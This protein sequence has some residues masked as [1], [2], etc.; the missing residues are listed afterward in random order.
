MLHQIA[1]ALDHQDYP[2]AARLL[3]QALQQSPHD[4]W[5][6]FYRARLYEVSGKVDPAEQIY[7]QLL[8]DV[9]NPK[10]ALQVRQGLQR[11]ETL[12]QAQ[13]QQAIA[14]A[15][16]QPGSQDPGFL[17]LEA[18]PSE[19]RSTVTQ[20]L[21]RV[22]QLDA[23]TAR[24]LVP[25]RGW[26]LYRTGAIGELG[27]HGR[28]LRQAGVPASWASQP[29]LEQI[30][31]FQVQ[32]FQA[33][34]PQVEVICKNAQDQLGQLNFDWTEVQQRVEG[35][36][37]I[38]EQVLELGY[39]DRLERKEK[40]QDYTHVCDLHL[41][42]RRCILRIVESQYNF[43]QGVA[44]VPQQ[45]PATGLDRATVRTNWN[46]LMAILQQRSPQAL[47]WSD[48]TLFGE[49]AADFAAP[50]SRIKSH[51]PLMRRT[52][53]HWD[54]AFQ[55]YSSLLCWRLGSRVTPT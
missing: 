33:M 28:A 15:N 19:A 31:V 7:R 30:Q 5:V 42:Q 10:L 20:S 6:Q 55:L 29:E 46:G 17:V 51:I 23:Y 47:V 54:A 34:G 16:D 2:T 24:L 12:Q 11:L 49:S 45:V 13:R 40:T 32:S 27:L 1:A 4:P 53:S 8:R 48:F 21:A 44:M 43:S 52:D 36:V 26:R 37:P 41:P 18:V 22:M 14:A 3:K 39:R 9:N 35:M 38:F 25:N 50:L